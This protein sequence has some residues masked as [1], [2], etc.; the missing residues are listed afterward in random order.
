MGIRLE[1]SGR[2]E[3]PQRSVVVGGGGNGGQEASRWL[4]FQPVSEGLGFHP[5]ADGLPYAPLVKTPYPGTGFKSAG[6]GAVAERDAERVRFTLAR[7][8]LRQ[9]PA[10]QPRAHQP[11][12]SPAQGSSLTHVPQLSPLQ[13]RLYLQQREGASIAPLGWRY[14][15]CR[16]LAHTADL[17]VNVLLGCLFLIGGGGGGGLLT[18][19]QRAREDELLAVLLLVS[20][21]SWHWLSL[22]LQDLSFRTSVGKALWGL[23]LQGSRFAILVRSLFLIPSAGLCGIGLFSGLLD[24]EGK[25][26]HDRMA[27]LQP[28]PGWGTTGARLSERKR[29]TKGSTD[30]RG[31]S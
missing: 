13:E 6:A 11:R 26:W 20:A 23:S 14:L 7:E 8:K 9:V 1:G 4:D 10:S 16:S 31:G 3:R 2:E 15:L 5:F 24:P 17:G 25:C 22:F 21:V 29:E 27:D 19:P 28:L 18:L 12:P 30:T